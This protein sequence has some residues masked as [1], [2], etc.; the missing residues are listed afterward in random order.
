MET[1][2]NDEDAVI[3]QWYER[4][5]GDRETRREKETEG[6]REN[7]REPERWWYGGRDVPA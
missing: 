4:A 6:G 5:A 3:S 2:A 1:R 7:A